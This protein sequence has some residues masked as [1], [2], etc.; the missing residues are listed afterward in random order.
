MGEGKPPAAATT[1]PSSSANHCRRSS[2]TAIVDDPL[3][4]WLHAIK[5]VLDE[6]SADRSVGDGGTPEKVVKDC[7]R[8][9]KDH[10]RYQNDVRELC[11]QLLAGA[12]H[13]LSCGIPRLGNYMEP[14]P[15]LDLRAPSQR[16]KL[17]IPARF[18]WR[19]QS[20]TKIPTTLKDSG[21][22]NGFR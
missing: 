2:I 1:P 12:V 4:P 8:N 21:D 15:F 20:P 19:A 7:I 3:L 17:R 5:V 18:R 13:P 22:V 10:S 6:L 11:S 16:V 14:S 9:F